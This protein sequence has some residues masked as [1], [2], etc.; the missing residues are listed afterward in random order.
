MVSMSTCSVC[1][2]VLCSVLYAHRTFKKTIAIYTFFMF[3]LLK[4]LDY[5]M[6]EHNKYKMQANWSQLFMYMY[7]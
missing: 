5:G 3:F 2:Y 4:C 1:L 7:Y 6:K